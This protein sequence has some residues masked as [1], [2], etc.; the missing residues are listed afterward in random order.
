MIVDKTMAAT[1][2]V[3]TDNSVP[4]VTPD[5]PATC[6]VSVERKDVKAP[7]VFSSLSKYSISCLS[8]VLNARSLTL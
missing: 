8:I 2:V 1:R 6:V 7:E 3:K 5:K 4:S